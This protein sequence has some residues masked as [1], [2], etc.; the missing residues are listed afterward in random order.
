MIQCICKAIIYEDFEDVYGPC[1][2]GMTLATLPVLL[3]RDWVVLERPHQAECDDFCKGLDYRR[4]FGNEL[5]QLSLSMRWKAIEYT[6]QLLLL[7][8]VRREGC[9]PGICGLVQE[10]LS[11][12]T[13]LKPFV[14]KPQI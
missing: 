5:Q 6:G 9:G 11:Y 8:G 14:L 3:P 4:S 13:A 10:I 7:P 2:C 1:G 12:G